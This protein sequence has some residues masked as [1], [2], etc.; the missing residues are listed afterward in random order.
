MKSHSAPFVPQNIGRLE[1]GFDKSM[2]RFRDLLG[3]MDKH[4]VDKSMTRSR[5]LLGQ[6]LI[7]GG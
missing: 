3:Q 6:M 1:H 2:T 4:G 5:D 7:S